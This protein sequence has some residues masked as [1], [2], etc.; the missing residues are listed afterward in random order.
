MR[1]FAKAAHVPVIDREDDTYRPCQDMADLMTQQ[2]K[3]GKEVDWNVQDKLF[4]A[5]RRRICDEQIMRL[6]ESR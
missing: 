6:R 2:E 5:D 3:L 1:A 4:D